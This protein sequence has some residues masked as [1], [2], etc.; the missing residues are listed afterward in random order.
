M[1]TPVYEWMCE[2]WNNFYTPLLIKKELK[3]CLLKG[4]DSDFL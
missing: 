4:Y 1:S 3:T 2:I